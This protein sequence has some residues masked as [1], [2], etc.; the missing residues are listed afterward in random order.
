VNAPAV[1][2]PLVSAG[3]SDGVVR[4][5]SVWLDQP[6]E[7]YARLHRLLSADERA[8]AARFVFERD[9]HRFVVCR[10]ALREALGALIDGEPARLA[11][12]YS[13]HGK[14]ALLHSD[15]EFNVSHAAGL[16]LFAFS[17]GTAVGV[18]VESLERRVDSETLAARF[19]S[20]DEANDLLMLPPPQRSEAFFNGWTRKESYIKA[21]GAG[22]SRPLDSFSVTLRPAD[23][24]VIRRIDGDDAREWQLTAF[25]PAPGFVAACA[26]RRPAAP[27][28]VCEWRD[29]ASSPFA[30]LRNSENRGQA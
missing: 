19:F 12:S 27:T 28:Y 15:V 5:E 11:F 22:M 6:D 14:P 2:S 17:K 1:E 21:I 29:A 8:R 9:R 23:P 10:G 13:R 16:A 30:I 25:R 3:V 20:R 26:T 24:V 7:V 18:D 4:I